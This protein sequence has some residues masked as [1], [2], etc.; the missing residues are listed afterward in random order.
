MSERE[1]EKM[2]KKATYT[3]VISAILSWMTRIVSRRRRTCRRALARV[4]HPGGV[5]HAEVR[6]WSV[7]GAFEFDRAVKPRLRARRIFSSVA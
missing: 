6:T 1:R 2:K 4:V 5:F 3:S 7:D